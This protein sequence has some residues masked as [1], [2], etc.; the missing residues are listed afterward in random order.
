MRILKSLILALLIVFPTVYQSLHQVFSH[1]H[2][3]ECCDDGEGALEQPEEECGVV[4]FIF[5]SQI[6]T[7]PATPAVSSAI[8]TELFSESLPALHPVESQYILIPR[9]PPVSC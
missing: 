1:H 5:Y 6:E 4:S 9:A 8:V 7:K 2:H 3:F